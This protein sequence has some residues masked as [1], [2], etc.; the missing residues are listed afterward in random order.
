MLWVLF[1]KAPSQDFELLTQVVHFLA[2]VYHSISR[3]LEDQRKVIYSD[4]VQESLQRLKGSLEDNS[5]VFGSHKRD[6]VKNTMIMLVH[7]LSD[8][9]V[10]GSAAIRPHFN[11]D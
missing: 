11:I 2:Q 4:F 3:V 1:Q 6:L 10:R 9:E 5:E 7:S 8:T